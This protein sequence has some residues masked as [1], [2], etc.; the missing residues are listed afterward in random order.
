[1]SINLATIVRI[2][3]YHSFIQQQNLD[4]IFGSCVLQ[5]VGKQVEKPHMDENVKF[6]T[7]LN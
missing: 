5:F 6:M 2:P 1:M 3:K 7:D 4:M